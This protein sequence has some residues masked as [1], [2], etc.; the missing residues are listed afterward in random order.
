VEEKTM[1]WLEV[2]NLHAEID[3]A[4]ARALWRHGYLPRVA[5][6]NTKDEVD[7]RA[8]SMSRHGSFSHE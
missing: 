7:T 3:G 2:K 8:Q 5:L 4:A 1:L 6:Y